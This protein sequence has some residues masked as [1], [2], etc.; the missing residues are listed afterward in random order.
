[1]VRQASNEESGEQNNDFDLTSIKNALDMIP[2]VGPVVDTVYDY[3]S[4]LLIN[5]DQLSNGL[6]SRIIGGSLPCRLTTT[7][8]ECSGVSK[9][10]GTYGVVKRIID[11]LPSTILPDDVKDIIIDFISMVINPI[12]N[13]L[14]G[15]LPI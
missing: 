5:A 6:L 15:G 14:F 1:M 13:T 9:N 8:L 4:E 2:G 11:M 3:V 10:G 7:S 12:A